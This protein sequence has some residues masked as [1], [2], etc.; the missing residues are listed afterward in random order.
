MKSWGKRPYKAT[1]VV[2]V[3]ALPVPPHR[4][5][6]AR[7]SMPPAKK[8]SKS[9][10]KQSSL[11]GAGMFPMLTKTSVAIGLFCLVPGAFCGYQLQPIARSSRHLPRPSLSATWRNS[12]RAVRWTSVTILDST[13]HRHQHQQQSSHA[14]YLSVALNGL[15]MIS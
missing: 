9:T 8:K 11:A 15:P 14:A 4:L 13:W 3:T 10:G 6:F 1:S 12:A 5:H 7:A 2:R